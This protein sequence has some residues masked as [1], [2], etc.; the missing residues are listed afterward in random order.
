MDDAVFSQ[1]IRLVNKNELEAGLKTVVDNQPLVFFHHYL[2][3]FFGNG[4]AGQPIF[5]TGRGI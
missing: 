2:G 3:H 4:G 5:R 1:M